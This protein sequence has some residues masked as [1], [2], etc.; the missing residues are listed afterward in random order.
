MVAG[1]M[2]RASPPKP[3]A[4]HGAASSAS[5]HARYQSPTPTRFDRAGFGRA[6]SSSSLAAYDETDAELKEL[7][8]SLL[9]RRHGRDSD[10]ADSASGSSSKVLERSTSSPELAALCD[11]ANAMESKERPESCSPELLRVWARAAELS[12]PEPGKHDRPHGAERS[13]TISAISALSALSRTTRL[14]PIA[15]CGGHLSSPELGAAFGVWDAV[16]ARARPRT[17]SQASNHNSGRP[18]AAPAPMLMRNGTPAF[19]SSSYGRGPGSALGSAGRADGAHA[20]GIPSGARRA[21]SPMLMSPAHASPA[22]AL[23]VPRSPAPAAPQARYTRAPTP[24]HRASLRAAPPAARPLAAPDAR[25]APWESRGLPFEAPAARASSAA[26]GN[27]SRGAA[28]GPPWTTSSPPQLASGKAAVA[29]AGISNPLAA[30]ACGLHGLGQRLAPTRLFATAAGSPAP[31]GFS[32]QRAPSRGAPTGESGDLVGRWV[33]QCDSAG[34]TRHRASYSLGEVTTRCNSLD[35]TAYWRLEWR[36]GA[37]Q[38]TSDLAEDTALRRC[39]L[40]DSRRRALREVELRTGAAIVP[41]SPATAQTSDAGGTDLYERVDGG[42]LPPAPRWSAAEATSLK[43]KLCES[44]KDLQRTAAELRRPVG[45]VLHLYYGTLKADATFKAQLKVRAS[46]GLAPT[47]ENARAAR[48]PTLPRRMRCGN[49]GPSSRSSSTISRCPRRARRRRRTQRTLRRS[50][51][52]A[53]RRCSPRTAPRRRPRRASADPT[54]AHPP[55]PQPADGG[56]TLRPR[57]DRTQAH[58]TA[59]PAA[60]APATAHGEDLF[61]QSSSRPARPPALPRPKAPNASPL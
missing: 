56:G 54:R 7:A 60:R 17:S 36:A 3:P 26:S 30:Y 15:P 1:R 49:G 40:F 42:A 34:A 46:S 39:T 58:P 31:R 19:A 22:H 57:E 37:R 16:D 47:F 52:T 41:P 12:T 43:R 38:S 11:V 6:G 55:T 21:S 35:G 59:A 18:F 61:V 45:D 4:Y 53:S 33:A 23:H 13:A 29:A 20:S 27:S 28:A 48:R 2:Q 5:S 51:C 24:D 8:S 14:T 44:A 50:L 9:P 32:R 25:T 10:G